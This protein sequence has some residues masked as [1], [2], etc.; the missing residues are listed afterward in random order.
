[1]SK[2]FPDSFL[3]FFLRSFKVQTLA[4]LEISN[5]NI[6]GTGGLIDFVFGSVVGFR[7]GGLNGTISGLIKI[8]LNPRWRP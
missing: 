3:I 6:S 4:I 1:M 8:K 5:D 7:D 2:F